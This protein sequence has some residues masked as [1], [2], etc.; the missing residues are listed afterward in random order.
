MSVLVRKVFLDI[1]RRKGRSFLLI[2]G[3]LI[4][5]L[6]FTTLNEAVD[7]IG[8][9]FFYSTDPAATPNITCIVSSLPPSVATALTRLPNVALVQERSL[10]LTFWHLGNGTS[11]T[12]MQITATSDLRPRLG[13]FQLISGH[14]PGPG[15]IVMDE[16]DQG[17]RPLPVGSAITID[18]PD[19]RHLS[20]RVAGLA[21]TRGLA[22]WHVPPAPLGYMNVAA[23]QNVTQQIR[24]PVINDLPRG[25]QL[26]IQTRDPSTS[27][28]TYQAVT[29]LLATAH[30]QPQ[31]FSGVRNT[32]F[33][34]DTQLGV[35]GVFA[36]VRL[37]TVL[38]LLLVGVMIAA[39][40][41][42]F[43]SEQ[44]KII[45]TMKALGGTR[46]PIMG[47]YLLTLWISS[48]VG[49][50]LGG[51]IGLAIGYQFAMHMAASATIQVANLLL[52]ITVGPFHVAAWVLVSSLLVGLV[53]PSLAGLWPL[54]TGTAIT[55]RQALAAYGV[56]VE[57]QARAHAWGRA[58]R[59]VPQTVWLGLRGF[60]RRPGRAAFTLLALGLAST[61][62]F[63]VQLTDASL[64]ANFA[65]V[66]NV[67]HSDLRVDLASSVGDA[68]PASQALAA[69]QALPNVARVEPIDPMPISI[70]HRVLELNGLLADTRLYQPQLTGGRWLRPHELGA[71]VINDEA[72][73]R[74]HLQVGSQVSVQYEAGTVH[75]T[76]VGIVHDIS[77]VSASGNPDGRLGETFTTMEALNQLRH[78]PANA[79]E[80]LWLQALNHSVQ[81]LDLLQQRAN[82]TLS[83]LGLQD[84]SALV[85]TQDLSGVSGT[86][87]FIAVLFDAAAILVAVIGLLSLSHTLATS[88]LERRLE[89]GILR[90]IGASGWRVG[91]I[92]G[93]EGLAQAF[94][95]WAAGIA[96][97]LPV[98]VGIL[99]LL[100]VFMGP[101]DLSFQ[102][103]TLLFTL[104]FVLAVASL[105]SFG[106][107]L[108]AAQVRVRSA[109]RYE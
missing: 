87:Q 48:A 4:G 59:A 96:L 100:S 7:L 32:S 74:L 46:L 5:V 25:T 65:Q 18:A 99:D 61:V 75:L 54:W 71:I 41:A 24:G 82:S 12:V 66:S 93:I 58:L 70:E 47:S 50:V 56:R 9:A 10:Y 23:L 11:R 30:I 85:L 69:L 21:R 8:D 44:F 49:T 22:I 3:I 68:V 13:D 79:A 109:L 6:G 45:G 40:V 62:F 17:L 36:I 27:A 31:T 53:F 51:G 42:A 52:P 86:L 26:L 33:D 106:P 20:L 63:S 2:L 91:M 14:L 77:E 64:L 108:T 1:T 101:I 72:S 104:C 94:L 15:E 73:T 55:V 95:A 92:F 39:I 76:V 98:A 35:S 57:A 89:I 88:V 78:L 90:A 16:S 102:P 19:G 67:Y 37:L 29:Q 107:V 38:T 80:R 105:A 34:A 60:L 103:L 43:L 84:G 97:G 81:A 83:R 28:Q